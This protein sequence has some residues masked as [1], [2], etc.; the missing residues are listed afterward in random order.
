MKSKFH[1]KDNRTLKEKISATAQSALFW[2]SR[3]KGMITTMNIKLNDLRA[4]FFPKGFYEKYQYLGAIPWNE[5]GKLFQA[6]EPLVIFMDY[7][8][9]P[10]WCPRWFLR[11]LHLFGNDN[12]IVRV[13]NRTLHNLKNRLT[14]GIMMVDHK[15]K[16]EW[17][18]LRISVHADSQTNELADMIEAHF[19]RQGQRQDMK[20]EILKLNPNRKDY[21]WGTTQDMLNE[22]D[23]LEEAQ[24]NSKN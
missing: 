2:R 9:K 3:N 17:Y 1:I 21:G 24:E 13:R 20:E 6:I 8:A 7:K 14:K 19:Y 15:T 23:A 4:V 10:S 18:D 22:L 11:F 16:W 12:S 5:D